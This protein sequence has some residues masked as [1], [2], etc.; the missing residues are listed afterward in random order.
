MKCYRKSHGL[1]Q[2][3]ID[4]CITLERGDTR[5]LVEEKGKDIR[6]PRIK[7]RKSSEKTDTRRN[8]INIFRLPTDNQS[9]RV[10]C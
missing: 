7:E 6:L 2:W 1:C 3:H 4:Y 8:N 5:C 9:R 10:Q